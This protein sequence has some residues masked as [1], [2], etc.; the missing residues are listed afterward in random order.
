L[1]EI[2]GITVCYDNV[3][4]LKDVS[5]SVKE[6]EVVA[7]LGLNGAGKTTTLLTAS[8]FLKPISG[9]IWFRGRRIDGMPPHK[10][11][12]LGLVHIPEGRRVFSTLKVWENLV[13][14]A[15]TRNDRNIKNDLG[16]VEKS[17]PILK[18][19]KD[20]LAGALSGGEQQMLAFGRG[21]MA[22]PQL[23]MMDEPILGLSPLMT[24]E[25]GSIIN[26]LMLKGFPILLVEQ[27]VDFVLKF[28]NRCYVLERGKIIFETSV[29]ELQS[30]LSSVSLK[31]ILFRV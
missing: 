11:V 27:N 5:I 31:K 7:F 24:Q 8:G 14:G 20:Q 6:G 25:V 15:Y 16:E 29:S 19:R 30:S 28:A 22:K 9:E 26:G 18:E 1:L 10:I 17:F 13:L 3:P 12:R 23:L 2:K 21:I 4:A